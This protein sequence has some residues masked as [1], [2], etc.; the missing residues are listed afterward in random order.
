MQLFHKENRVK[1]IVNINKKRLKEIQ[2]KLLNTI[3]NYFK[4]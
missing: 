4:I 2:E 1:E 3:Y